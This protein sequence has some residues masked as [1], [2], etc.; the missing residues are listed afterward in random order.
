MFDQ[1]YAQGV[2]V[3]GMILKPNMVLPG[4]SAA[5]QDPVDKV[6]DETVRCLLRAVPAAVAGIAF[7]SGGQPG[8]LATARLNAMHIRFRGHLPWPLTFSFARAIQAPALNIWQGRESQVEAAQNALY[9]RAIGNRAARR[10]EFDAT[11]AT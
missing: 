8:E 6:A 2:V 3:D 5:R 9:A 1:L 7:L 4:L 11:I 10:G